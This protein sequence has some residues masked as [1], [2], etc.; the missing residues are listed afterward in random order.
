VQWERGI[1]RSQ[2]YQERMQKLGS[3]FIIDEVSQ[4]CHLDANVIFLLAQLGLSYFNTFAL[5]ILLA[6]VS[7]PPAPL[8]SLLSLVLILPC[9]VP[10]H[11]RLLSSTTSPHVLSF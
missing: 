11:Q 3:E 5:A 9:S 7:V 6:S 1:L 8:S 10:P 2:A 4:V